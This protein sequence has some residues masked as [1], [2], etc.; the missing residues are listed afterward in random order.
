MIIIKSCVKRKKSSKPGDY[1]LDLRKLPKAYAGKQE[2]NIIVEGILPSGEKVI[3]KVPFR[4]KGLPDPYGNIDGFKPEKIVSKSDLM[5]SIIGA[6]FGDF[7]FELPL[8]VDKFKIYVQGKGT[9]A[10]DGNELSAQAKQAVRTAKKGTRVTVSDIIPSAIGTDLLI[11]PASDIN[12]TL[13]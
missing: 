5:N 12:L 4:L 10:C 7:D 6:D 13:K 8:F 2:I 9:F 3:T 11:A 1:E